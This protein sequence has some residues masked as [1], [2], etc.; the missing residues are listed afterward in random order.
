MLTR[1]VMIN[2]ANHIVFNKV[3][4]LREVDTWNLRL[5]ARTRSEL[6]FQNEQQM[7]DYLIKA[8]PDST[9]YFSDNPESFNLCA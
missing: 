8:F 1:S 3:D 7:K 6:I 9:L 4:I 5:N 2:G